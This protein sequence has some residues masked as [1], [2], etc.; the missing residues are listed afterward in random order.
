MTNQLDNQTLS[1]TIRFD[2]WFT[3]TS[4]NIMSGKE[5]KDNTCTR[6]KPVSYSICGYI[7]YLMS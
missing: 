2:V 4:E 3:H 1:K 7:F 5:L 6:K